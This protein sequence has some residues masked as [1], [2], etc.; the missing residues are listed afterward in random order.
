MRKIKYIKYKQ[1]I[2]PTKKNK[3]T[4]IHLKNT[5]IVTFEDSSK[6]IRKINQTFERLISNEQNLAAS[7]KDARYKMKQ[8]KAKKNILMYLFIKEKTKKKS[9]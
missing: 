7:E 9:L 5:I 1:K 3:N 6:K 4:K 8:N 2:L